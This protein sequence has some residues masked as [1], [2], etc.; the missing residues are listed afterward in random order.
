[1]H[2]MINVDGVADRAEENLLDKTHQPLI[3]DG[4]D[5]ANNKDDNKTEIN[6]KKSSHKWR[7][8]IF[9]LIWLLSAWHLLTVKEKMLI[10]HNIVI[11]SQHIK[12]N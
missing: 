11:E 9:F 2:S 12:S 3:M 5:V 1:M 10:K 4:M 7:Y 8:I 6:G